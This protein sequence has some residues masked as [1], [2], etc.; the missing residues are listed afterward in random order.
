MVGGVGQRMLSSVSKRMAGEFFSNVGTA[1]SHPRGRARPQTRH[2]TGAP[3]VFTAPAK[4]GGISSQDD[5][6]K[7]IVVG[8]GLVRARRRRRLDLRAPPVTAAGVGVP[9]APG[10]PALPRE[11]CAQ[12]VQDSPGQCDGSGSMS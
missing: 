1:I 7:G 3:G 11:I 9:G 8:A 10:T 4:A 2:A 5:F 6:L 12:E